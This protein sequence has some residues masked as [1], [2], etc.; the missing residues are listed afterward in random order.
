MK[1]NKINEWVE[2]LKEKPFLIDNCD[3]LDKFKSDDWFD[4]L[5]KQP[6]LIE[7]FND[8]AKMSS[9]NWLKLLEKYPEILNEY[10]KVLSYQV[11]AKLIT[12]SNFPKISSV[13]EAD[14]KRLRKLL[15][16]SN[17]E[18][19]KILIKEYINKEYHE[20]VVLTEMILKYP[21]LKEF[22]TKND[23][24]MYVDTTKLDFKLNYEMLK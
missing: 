3:V 5:I 2:L 19:Y 14:E 20:P 7:H 13:K 23:L 4:I 8:F 1:N 24:W 10:P 11:I 6:L 9:D 16:N 12:V 22:Y 18:T 17:K 15:Y 21:D